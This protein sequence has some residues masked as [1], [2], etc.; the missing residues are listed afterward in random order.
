MWLMHK[1]SDIAEEIETRDPRRSPEQVFEYVDVSAVD[2]ATLKITET[3]ETIG[4]K[5][6][7]RARRVIRENDVIFA[8]IRP[9]LK[10]VAIVPEH[11]DNQICSTGYYVLRGKQG[12]YGPFLYYYLQTDTFMSEMER[13]QRGASYPAVSDTDIKNQTIPLPPL[14]EQKRIV[15]ILDQAF[16]GIDKAIANT[17]Q[18]LK[19]AR[20]LFDSYLSKMF[21]EGSSS[22]AKDELMN[23]V[24]QTCSLSYGIVQPGNDFPNG[25]PVVRPTD[26]GEP[27]IRRNGLK[28]INPQNAASYKR[29]TLRGNDLLLCVRGSTGD[30]SM[31]DPELSGANV[32]RGLVPIR[33][34]KHKIL[35]KFGY[36]AFLAKPLRDQ[37][38][39][40]TYGAALMQINIRDV[41]KLE[42]AFPP[43]QQQ[44]DIVGQLDRADG[45]AARLLDTQEKKLHALHSLKQSLLQKAFSGELNG[46]TAQEAVKVA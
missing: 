16:E 6:P 9:T 12:V 23:L 29:T 35:Q 19:N 39:A 21:S 30:V 36:Y 43:L 32:T 31:A 13:L 18:N 20:E 4:K 5:A 38:K 14:D 25:L 27:V 28:L 42:L 2:R 24:D 45:A 33:F 41:K 37:I 15:A 34:E 10:R 7:S 11:L 22:W 8:T 46:A 44:T 3:T 26:L 1:I 17:E 40:K